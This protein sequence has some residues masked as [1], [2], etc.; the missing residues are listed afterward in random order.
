[1]AGEDIKPG[2]KIKRHLVLID[3][4]PELNKIIPGWYKLRKE[5]MN[6]NNEIFKAV[7]QKIANYMRN[8]SEFFA[9]VK[10]LRVKSMTQETPGEDED[11]SNHSDCKDQSPAKDS[12]LSASGDA[13]VTQSAP[14]KRARREPEPLDP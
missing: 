14:Q 1:M 5:D 8:E 7:Y 3:I 13:S 10:A 2:D 4:S 6:K 9:Q 11:S 12:A